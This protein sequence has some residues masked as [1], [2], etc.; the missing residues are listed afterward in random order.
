[1][2]TSVIN[3]IK[4]KVGNFDESKL[5]TPLSELGIDSLDV[6]DIV[7][8]VEDEFSEYHWNESCA[9]FNN[10]NTPRD[11]VNALHKEIGGGKLSNEY[12]TLDMLSQ[13]FKGLLFS[14]SSRLNPIESNEFLNIDNDFS[15]S[16]DILDI[17][18][19]I[20]SNLT[21]NGTLEIRLDRDGKSSNI[22]TTQIGRKII[23]STSYNE[24]IWGDGFV[25]EYYKPTC[26]GTSFYQ[27]PNEN[28]IVENNGYKYLTYGFAKWSP[29]LTTTFE[30]YEYNSKL[31]ISWLEFDDAKNVWYTVTHT[32]GT[33]ENIV[34][35]KPSSTKE[36]NLQPGDVVKYYKNDGT[37]TVQKSTIYNA[38]DAYDMVGAKYLYQYEISIFL[39][40]ETYIPQPTDT[41]Y[42][43]NACGKMVEYG[44]SEFPD[45]S[46]HQHISNYNELLKQS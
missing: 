24:P 34:I 9:F 33:S 40:A 2:L 46:G 1:M 35:T 3:S 13:E 43:C 31:N 29:K 27:T 26:K 42:W 32:D 11:I 5:D 14:V 44:S 30:G 6:V 20:D 36:F 22:L 45:G 25:V 16:P 38:P 10:I 39:T 23:L 12:V 8:Q 7:T 4:D 18:P 28:I 41:E 17:N 37:S 15:R 19:S 21:L